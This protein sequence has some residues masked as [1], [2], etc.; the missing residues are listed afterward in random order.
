MTPDTRR[1]SDTVRIFIAYHRPWKLMDNAVCTPIHVGRALETEPDKD[2]GM[3]AKEIAWLRNNMIGDDTGDSISPLNRRY[4]ELTAQYWVWKNY[5]AAGAP[6]YVGFMHYRRHLIFTDAQDPPPLP[7]VSRLPGNLVRFPEVSNAYMK[8]IGLT[9]PDILRHLRD[10]EV[11]TVNPW[12]TVNLSVYVYYKNVLAR[13]ADLPPESIDRTA[14]IVAR[15]RPEYK[16]AMER[17]VNGLSHIDYSI[18]LMK[19]DIYFRYMEFLF[20]ILERIDA[21]F[22]YRNCSMMRLRLPAYL[23]ERLHGIFVTKLLEEG[24]ARVLFRPLAFIDSAK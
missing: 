7:P 19:K 10:A 8:N 24:K 6:A 17:Y 1:K 18:Y 20:P 13:M 5:T 22:D 9:A 23:A 16:S 4:C 2:G 3:D 11:I 21:S 12:R 14:E 15:L